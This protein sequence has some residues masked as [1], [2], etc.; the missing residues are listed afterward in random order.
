MPIGKEA[1][2]VFNSWRH[3]LL[4]VETSW[5]FLVKP[6]FTSNYIQNRSPIG[7]KAPGIILIIADCPENEQGALP[8]AAD[9]VY[10]TCVHVLRICSN[11][12]E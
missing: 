3:L 5:Y 2:P 10:T 6:A 12:H 1:Q 9:I 11:E 4:F 8:L 7:K